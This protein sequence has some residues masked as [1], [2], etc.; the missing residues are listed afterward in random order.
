MDGDVEILK[1]IY[2]RFN[3]RDIDAQAGRR[4]GLGC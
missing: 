1:R 3:S 4:R 2:D